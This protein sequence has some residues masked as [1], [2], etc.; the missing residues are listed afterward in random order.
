M[1]MENWG[2]GQHHRAACADA[3]LGQ[4]GQR[5]ARVQERDAAAATDGQAHEAL[6]AGYSGL[7]A[8][9]HAAKLALDAACLHHA[10]MLA[11]DEARVR[12]EQS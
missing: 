5:A 3:Q 10:P 1:G 8:A 11:A 12:A 4:V 9:A 2:C 6:A 7:L